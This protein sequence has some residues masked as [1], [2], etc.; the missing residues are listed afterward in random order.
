M[1]PE[2]VTLSDD[3][4]TPLEL[5]DAGELLLRE[6]HAAYI[7]KAQAEDRIARTRAGL[8]VLM[9]DATE[10]AVHGRPAVTWRPQV[11]KRF[12]QQTAKRFLTAEQIEACMVE[13]TTRPFRPVAAQ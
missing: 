12:D 7:A 1:L 3:A 4:V 9:G 6:L 5:G 8:E 13:Q 2:P 11:S 10:A